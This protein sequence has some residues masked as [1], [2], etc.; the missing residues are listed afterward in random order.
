MD[1]QTV[2]AEF[3]ALCKEGK[4]SEAGERFWAEDVVSIEPMGPAPV[5]KGIPAL[6]GKA[7]WWYDNH[8]VHGGTTEGP[9]VGGDA[10]AVIFALDVTPK[11]SGQRMTMRE[12]ALYTVR[13]GKVVEERFL[14]GMG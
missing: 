13:D 7:Q 3:V 12:V 4:F 11:A 2:A 6:K 8:E 10:F 5:S 9:F 14:Y 1:T